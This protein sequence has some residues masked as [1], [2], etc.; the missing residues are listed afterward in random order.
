MSEQP[1]SAGDDLITRWSERLSAGWR[2]Y[3]EGFGESPHGTQKQCAALLVLA[4]LEED[5]EIVLN[6]EKARLFDL[7]AAKDWRFLQHGPIQNPIH[8]VVDFEEVVVGSGATPLEAAQN[9]EKRLKGG[10]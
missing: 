7:L 6:A 9:A 2:K 5:S 4:H 1:K 10:A 3:T 8:D